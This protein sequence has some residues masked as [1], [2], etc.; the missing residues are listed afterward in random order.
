MS[1]IWKDYN[2]LVF[3]YHPVIDLRSSKTK[4]PDRIEYHTFLVLQKHLVNIL[5][6]QFPW[7]SYKFSLY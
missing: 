2:V 1:K 7:I 6:F 5:S 4:V 3:P